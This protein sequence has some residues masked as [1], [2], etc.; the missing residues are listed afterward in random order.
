[1]TESLLDIFTHSAIVHVTALVAAFLFFLMA[2]LR[3][4]KNREPEG[5]LFFT[6]ALFF[7]LIHL[8]YIANLPDDSPMANPFR[9]WSV[10]NW[11]VVLATPALIVLY[12]VLG[13]VRCVLSRF[14]Q[15][16]YG[17]FFGLTLLCYVYLLGGNWPAD[18]KAILT[19]IWGITW[20]NLELNHAS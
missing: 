15:G 13:A 18:A 6:L 2:G 8:F 1:M 12:L 7:F 5:F 19:L 14:H 20:F 11:M 3:S 17:I 9:N 10:W 4:V 16:L